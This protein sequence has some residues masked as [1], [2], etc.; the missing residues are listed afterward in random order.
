M[1]W[2]LK[3]IDNF[4]ANTWGEWW[5]SGES[6]G[7]GDR[8]P[9]CQ[10]WL[11]HRLP[12]HCLREITSSSWPLGPYSQ[13]ER[14]GISGPF[15]TLLGSTF[16]NAS[17]VQCTIFHGRKGDMTCK[18]MVNCWPGVHHME[19]WR[20]FNQ[21]NMMFQHIQSKQDGGNSAMVL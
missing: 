1:F 5:Y 20:L 6:T 16:C 21:S 11:C 2:L 12:L 14:G 18:R 3:A 17:S 4:Q 10:S 8:S 19:Q 15:K 9:T 7:L 13:N